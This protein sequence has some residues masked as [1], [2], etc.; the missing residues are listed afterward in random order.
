MVH[1][2]LVIQ[3]QIDVEDGI[4][5]L[6][7]KGCPLSLISSTGRFPIILLYGLALPVQLHPAADDG[8]GVLLPDR[9]LEGLTVSFRGLHCEQWQLLQVLQFHFQAEGLCPELLQPFVIRMGRPHLAGIRK[10]YFADRLHIFLWFISVQH[11]FKHQ[12]RACRQQQHEDSSP[13]QYLATV[14]LPKPLEAY[15]FLTARRTSLEG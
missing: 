7:I 4:E 9:I 3:L 12:S 15:F 13:C 2:L 11:T 10:C 5:V 8:L 6:I 14:F 1:L